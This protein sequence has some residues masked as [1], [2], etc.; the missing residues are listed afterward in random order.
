MATDDGLH[1]LGTK[2]IHQVP[3]W[4]LMVIG[5]LLDSTWLLGFAAGM[6]AVLIFGNLRTTRGYR[7]RVDEG[8]TNDC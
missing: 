7:W 1:L 6:L 2:F 4:T 3:A 5:T 8:E